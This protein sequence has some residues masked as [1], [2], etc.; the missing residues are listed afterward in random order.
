MNSN[1]QM[2]C[3][4]AM[5]K[6]QDASH[7]LSVAFHLETYSKISADLYFGWAMDSFKIAAEALGFELVEKE[8]PATDTAQSSDVL[9]TAGPYPQNGG[10]APQGVQP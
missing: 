5:H 4:A 3:N 9:S 10:P 2:K 7:C 8:K 6:M 1:Q